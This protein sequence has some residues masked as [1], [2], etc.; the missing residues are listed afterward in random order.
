MS[1]ITS[2]NFP[3]TLRP[4]LKVIFNTE[5]KDKRQYH[6]DIFTKVDSD[7]QYEERM[8]MVGMGVAVVG[9]M[10]FATLFGLFLI[11]A[12]YIVTEKAAA[13][14]RSS[15]LGGGIKPYFKKQK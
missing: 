10:T 11:P 5:Q 4:G 9:G 12:F 1:I 15:K 14:I 13:A 8:G 3:K 6:L 2:G 7:K